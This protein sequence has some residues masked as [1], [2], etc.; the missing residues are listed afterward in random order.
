MFAVACCV[1]DSV[2]DAGWVVG[3]RVGV[4]EVEGLVGVHGG[5]AEWAFG[6]DCLG[7]EAGSVCLVVVAVAALAGGQLFAGGVAAGAGLVSGCGSS[8]VGAG[9]EDLAFAGWNGVVFGHGKAR[10]FAGCRDTCG[11]GVGG[12]FAQVKVQGSYGSG[13]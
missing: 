9:A 10:L 13:L 12:C 1:D 7:E 5:V 11:A 8:A 4:V 6:S 2:C 3:S